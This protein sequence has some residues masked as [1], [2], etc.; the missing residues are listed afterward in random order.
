MRAVQLVRRQPSHFPFEPAEELDALPEARQ[1]AER[2][3]AERE[4][5]ADAVVIVNLIREG[6]PEQAAAN[7]RYGG[8]MLGA[9]AEGGYG[10]LHVGRAV[11]VERDYDFDSVAI[12]YY[13]GVDFF[14]EMATSRF[15]QGIVGNKQLAD[16]QAVVTVPILD[17][18]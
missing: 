15:F 12:V 8:S 2:L 11:R 18:L 7:R 4:L 5:G 13:P 14:A 9:M 10:P 16:T 6:T 1:L 3:R 17:R